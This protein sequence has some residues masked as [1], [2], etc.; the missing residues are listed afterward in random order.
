M[1]SLQ[2]LLSDEDKFF[3][4]LQASADEA[5]NCVLALVKLSKASDRTNA[6]Y[7]MVQSR[8]KEKQ[9]RMQITEAVYTTFVTPLEREDIENLSHALYR[10]PKSVQ[11]F[12]D[13]LMMNPKLIEGVD[14]SQQIGLIDNATQ[15]IVE[16]VKTLRTGTNPEKIK[17]LSEKLQFFEGEADKTVVALLKDVFT[18]ETDPI[19]VILL[20]DLY[21]LLEK[22]IDRCRDVGS[23]I[24]Q[25]VLKNS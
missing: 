5:R 21:E 14:F 15:V 25:I 10:I 24:S 17:S 2:R 6:N 8:R 19:K 11:K 7:E 20:K 23:I 22:I 12:G 13:R 4:M 18:R 3:D 16:M 1:F 9:I